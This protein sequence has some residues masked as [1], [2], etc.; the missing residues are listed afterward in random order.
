VKSQYVV[1]TIHP[2]AAANDRIAAALEKFLADQ[3]IRR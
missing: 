2:T 1:D 3:H